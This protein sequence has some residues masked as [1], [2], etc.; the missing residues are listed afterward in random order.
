MKNLKGIRT[1]KGTVGQLLEEVRKVV[2]IHS[3][4]TEE[5]HFNLPPV[6]FDD[7]K[8]WV[9]GQTLQTLEGKS[10]LP[11]HAAKAY[12]DKIH[13]GTGVDY[14]I[15]LNTPDKVKVY[16]SAEQ[17]ARQIFKAINNS[18]PNVVPHEW[19]LK[20]I[21]NG[22][23]EFA[24]GEKSPLIFLYNLTVTTAKRRVKANKL[25]M[26]L[27]PELISFEQD[28]VGDMGVKYFIESIEHDNTVS[29]FRADG[30]EKSRTAKCEHLSDKTIIKLADYL[31]GHTKQE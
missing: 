28:E 14:S 3:I 26:L 8:A 30:G 24:L 18:E 31:H 16:I 17:K 1:Y 7:F 23:E 22:L 25:N 5:E 15:K 6:L 20:C 4:Y 27:P 11:Y 9:V 10:Y 2:G 12:Y 13:T 29:I 21:A 19:V